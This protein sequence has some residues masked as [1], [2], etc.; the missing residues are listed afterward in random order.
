MARERGG[1]GGRRLGAPARLGEHLEAAFAARAEMLGA[2]ARM[3]RSC[4]SRPAARRMQRRSPPPSRRRGCRRLPGPAEDAGLIRITLAA[5]RFRHP[6]VRSA[7][8]HSAAPSSG[9]EPTRRS[10][11]PL[12]TAIRKRR[13]GIAPRRRQ[14]PT[15][16]VA[17]ALEQTADRSARRGASSAASAAF[18]A[19]AR[20]SP[21]QSDRARRLALGGRQAWLAGQVARAGGL[22]DDATAACADDGLRAELLYLAARSSS[23]P[24]D[25]PSH[26]GCCSRRLHWRRRGIRP[27]Q[28]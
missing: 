12:P 28:R 19:S 4:C 10:P 5:I 8:Y 14:G 23:S 7:L 16:S 20:L 3:R 11:P 1:A 21:R 6:L 26:T 17:A 15:R 2:G 9:A 22:V 24:D 13:R 27:A 25:R 18:E